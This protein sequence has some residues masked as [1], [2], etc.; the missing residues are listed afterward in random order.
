MQEG[1][2]AYTWAKDIFPLNRSLTGEGVSK[3]LGYFK[4]IC[5]DLQICNIKSGTKVFDWQIPSEWNVKE[6][7]V[8]NLHGKKIIDFKKNNLHLMGYSKPINKILTYNSLKKHLYSLKSQ[9]NA[10]PYITSYYKKNWGFCISHKKKKL[11]KKGRYKVVIDSNF[12]KGNLKYGEIY[13]K[14]KKNK[15]I[16]ISTNIC[17]P[18]M[19]NN[20]T[21]GPVVSLA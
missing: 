3:T 10:I 4:K 9:P 6:A 11:L 21:S 1:K 19:G 15:E 2:K 8:S 7:Y 20:E 16:L 13:L 5:S 14:G 12:K 18:S 17:H